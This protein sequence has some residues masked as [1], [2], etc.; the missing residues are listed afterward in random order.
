M[1]NTP[2]GT[3]TYVHH[4]TELYNSDKELWISEVQR[5]GKLLYN[6]EN[7]KYGAIHH[8]ETDNWYIIPGAAY[9]E[10]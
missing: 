7:G 1:D 8:K 3:T 10:D 9:D 5:I 2:D 4:L 6:N